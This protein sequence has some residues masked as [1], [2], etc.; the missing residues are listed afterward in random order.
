MSNHEKLVNSVTKSLPATLAPGTIPPVWRS[1][2][3]GYRTPPYYL[4]WRLTYDQ[5]SRLL[6]PENDVK[7]EIFDF[8]HKYI[9]PRWERLGYDQKLSPEVE[10]GLV[11]GPMKYS[12]WD[13][14]VIV[15]AFSN[16]SKAT[17][18]ASQD[19]KAKLIIEATRDSLNLP[20]ELAGGI[21]WHT[22]FPRSGQRKD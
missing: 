17:I 8:L 1:S 14:E 20:E 13:Q 16:M 9:L 4:G 7:I 18:A 2:H 21:G 19:P 5:L 15:F 22:Y 11:L 3:G 10:P 12:P 6:D